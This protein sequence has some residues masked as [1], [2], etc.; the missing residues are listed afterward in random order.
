[1][2]FSKPPK[3]VGRKEVLP[4]GDSAG[5]IFARLLHQKRMALGITSR[6]K[7]SRMTRVSSRKIVRA[8]N[9]QASLD[10]AEALCKAIGFKF[11]INSTD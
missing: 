4:D 10:T 11:S 6:E 1:M 9:G 3:K 7:L 2:R 8:E 5:A